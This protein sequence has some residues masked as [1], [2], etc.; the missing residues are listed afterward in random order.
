MKTRNLSDL[1]SLSTLVCEAVCR[2][3]TAT[4]VDGKVVWSDG[5]EIFYDPA[6]NLHDTMELV[7]RSCRGFMVYSNLDSFEL[8]QPKYYKVDVFTNCVNCG[9]GYGRTL[10]EAICRALIHKGFR[11]TQPKR[12]REIMASIAL[13]DN[14]KNVLETL[15]FNIDEQTA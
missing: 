7:E 15:Q 5:T 11:T 3:T 9:S 6:R 2:S 8:I 10:N 13:V 4:F 1:D 14:F 12:G